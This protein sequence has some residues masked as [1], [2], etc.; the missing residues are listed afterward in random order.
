MRPI[1]KVDGGPVAPDRRGKGI[2]VSGRRELAD[3]PAHTAARIGAPAGLAV[4]RDVARI[5]RSRETRGTTGVLDG[6]RRLIE[7]LAD[8]PL[9]TASDRQA[10][11]VELAKKRRL[12]VR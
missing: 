6:S 2:G 11:T 9:V 7:R 3:Q 12:L 4:P 8:E 10:L 5:P 1:Q